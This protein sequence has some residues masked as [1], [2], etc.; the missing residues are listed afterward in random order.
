M[1]DWVDQDAPR[2]LSWFST[3]PAGPSRDE[4]VGRFSSQLLKSDPKLAIKAVSSISDPQQRTNRLQQLASEWMNIDSTSARQW[5]TDS[6]L[7]ANFKQQLLS[8]QQ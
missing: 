6:D 4:L 1:Q 7:D 5:V 2:A 8:R 3:V